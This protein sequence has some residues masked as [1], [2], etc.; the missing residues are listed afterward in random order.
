MLAELDGVDVIE[1]SGAGGT[2]TPEAIRT[3]LPIIQK[4]SR[5]I[6]IS[7]REHC[8]IGLAPLAYLEAIKLGVCLLDTAVTPLANDVSLPSTENI[9]RNARRMGYSA[10]IDEEA[11]K[12]ESDYFRKVAQERGL[13]IG[14]LLEYDVFQFEH[15]VPGGMM[16]TLRNQLAELGMEHRLDELLEEIAQ[17]RQDFGYPY[18]STPYSQ[19]VAAQS[20]YNITSGERYKT[21][22]KEA[23]QYALGFFGEP[24]GPMDPN[25]KDKIL[26]SPWAKKLMKQKVP[27]ITIE[28]LRKLE[29]GISDD[30]LLI[31]IADPEGEFKEKLK[32]LWE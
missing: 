10:N 21:I 24:D 32:A 16:G 18:M 2:L 31:R 23:A 14:A 7:I 11:L 22:P 30:D 19:I 1:F 28:D 9:L 27:D 12:A 5:G 15:Q 8:N 6:T 13:R 25:I 17:T 20:V 26:S 29:P 3:L 4:E